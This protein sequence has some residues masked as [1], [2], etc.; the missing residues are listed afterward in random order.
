MGGKGRELC[1]D[2]LYTLAYQGD[3]SVDTKM[4][5]RGSPSEVEARTERGNLLTERDGLGRSRPMGGLNLTRG[6]GNMS[7]IQC[8]MS[9]ASN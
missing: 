4:T 9:I 7:T 2:R 3:T 5:S 1:M 6:F 8:D